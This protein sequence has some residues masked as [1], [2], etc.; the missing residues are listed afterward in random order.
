MDRL[1][2]LLEQFDKAREAAQVRLTGLGDEEYLWEPAPGSW[3]LRPRAEATT[4]RAFGPGAWVMDLGAA[5]IPASEYAE[6]ARQAADGMTVDKIAEDWS[7]SV[8]RVREVLAHTGEPEP[9]ETPVTTIAWRIAHLHFHFQGGWEWTFGERRRE[10]KELVDFTLR[11]PRARTVLG[12]DRPLARQRRH[13]HG[14]TARHG[15][16]LAVPVRLRS[17]RS[18]RLRPGRVQPGVHPPHGRDRPAPRPVEGPPDDRRV[19]RPSCAP[20]RSVPCVTRPA[21]L[22]AGVRLESIQ[23]ATH[24]A[25]DTCPGPDRSARRRPAALRGRPRTGPPPG[26]G[27][28]DGGRQ[29]AHGHPAHA[30]GGGLRGEHRSPRHGAGRLV[31]DH[32]RARSRRA[33]PNPGPYATPVASL[34]HRASLR[35][36]EA[37]WCAGALVDE[38]GALCSQGAIRRESGGDRRLEAQA[39]EVLLEAIRRRFG[40]SVESVPTFNDAWA[41]GSEPT[42]MMERASVL[43]DARGI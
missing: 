20:G 41:D 28:A 3:S 36:R 38:D 16:L 14:G 22:G 33:G 27:G 19:G 37:G 8:E 2:L 9:D 35:L 6:V 26:A 5:D 18:L 30:G 4:P 25:H 12:P 13:P 32:D 23:H 21:V 11:G 15:R 40:P 1:G 42:R 39:M 34:L 43:A 31:P 7:V 24:H 10:P 17:R 29:A